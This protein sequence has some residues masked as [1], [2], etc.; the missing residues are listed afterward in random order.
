M[1][2]VNHASTHD[3]EERLQF[4]M[5]LTEMYAEF[6]NLPVDWADAAI[7][8]AQRRIC[9]PFTI[10][11]AGGFFPDTLFDAQKTFPWIL[12]QVLDGN[13]AVIE[14]VDDLPPEVDR[15]TL[16]CWGIKPFLVM[17]IMIQFTLD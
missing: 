5:L 15:K 10:F 7:E 9:L 17:P 11:P 13:H 1:T 8:K 12:S 6:I 4:E 3:V 16:R 2:T 14:R